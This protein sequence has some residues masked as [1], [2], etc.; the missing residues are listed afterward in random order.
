MSTQA[1]VVDINA[2]R[3]S[4]QRFSSVAVKR[5]DLQNNSNSHKS[6]A[7]QDFFVSDVNIV[8]LIDQIHTLDMMDMSQAP[9]RRERQALSGVINMLKSWADFD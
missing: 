2:Y 7:I 9:T 1:K 5:A 3:Q 4:K 6:A 8:T